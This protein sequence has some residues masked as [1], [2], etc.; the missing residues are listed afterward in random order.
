[1]MKI[2]FL[3]DVVGSPGR[4]AVIENLG[5]IKEEH[6]IDFIIVNGEPELQLSRQGI[7][8]GISER[9]SITFL[10]SLAY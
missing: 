8:F 7:M 4:T 3:G 10:P 6:L 5:K 1:M 9:S 2:L